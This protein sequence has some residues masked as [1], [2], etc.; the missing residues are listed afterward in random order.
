MKSAEQWIDEYANWAE[1]PDG[2]YEFSHEQL[3]QLLRTWGKEVL[4][5]AANRAETITVYVP[6]ATNEMQTGIDQ[7]S[8][9][10]IIDQL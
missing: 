7:T 5:E 8:I 6:G 3:V 9:T 2:R 1:E 4:I 10:A